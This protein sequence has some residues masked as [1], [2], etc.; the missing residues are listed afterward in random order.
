MKMPYW[1]HPLTQA[2]PQAQTQ[3]ETQAQTQTETILNVK[4]CKNQR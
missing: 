3:A 4:K 2:Q 1:V